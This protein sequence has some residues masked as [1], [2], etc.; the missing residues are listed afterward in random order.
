MLYLADT[1]QHI[2]LS[3]CFAERLRENQSLLASDAFLVEAVRVRG[4]LCHMSAGDFVVHK[5]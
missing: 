5:I 2:P 4:L 1:G 3:K